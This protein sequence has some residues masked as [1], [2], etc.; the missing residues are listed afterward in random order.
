MYFLNALVF[1][2]LH[3]A[4]IAYVRGLTIKFANSPTCACRGTSGQTSVW[5]DD[6]GISAFHS[7]LVVD[8]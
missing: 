3:P 5:F 1:I 7:C 2:H 4:F 8:V 6:V